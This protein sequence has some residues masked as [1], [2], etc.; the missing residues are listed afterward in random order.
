[1]TSPAPTISAVS[2]S[3]RCA[4]TR[5]R[6]DVTGSRSKIVSRPLPADDPRQG[7]PDRQGAPRAGMD[8]VYAAQGGAVAHHRL[9]RGPPE[10]GWRARP[11]RKREVGGAG[12][13]S[14]SM[15]FVGASVKNRYR[16][17]AGP[18]VGRCQELSGPRRNTFPLNSDSERN[19][20]ACV[21]Q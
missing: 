14:G 8:A 3:F 12:I 7:Q 4:S 10:R 2:A 9:F 5:D 17:P 19:M 1:M 16:W 20:F 18:N 11:G 6:I 21:L 15:A 13:A